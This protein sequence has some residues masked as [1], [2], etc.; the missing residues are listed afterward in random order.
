MA[1][2][3]TRPTLRRK[4]LNSVLSCL[5][6]DRIGPGELSAELAAG[7]SRRL[8]AGG[9]I[10]LSSYAAAIARAVELLGLAPGDSVVMSALTPGIYRE[11]CARFGIR[12]A[13]VDIEERSP[14]LDVAAVQR[15]LSGAERPRALVLHYTFGFLP[16]TD[17]VLR[18]G[19]PVVEDLSHALG[20]S[21]NGGPCGSHGQLAILSLQPDGIVTTGQGA[22]LVG[23][24]RRTGRALGAWSGSYALDQTL[25]NMNAALGLA[26][27]RELD[28][29]L[30]A[31]QDIAEGYLQ[32]VARSPHGALTA[33]AQSAGVAPDSEGTTG[34]R[35]GAPPQ[36]GTAAQRRAVCYGFAVTVRGGLK[37]VRQYA[38]KRGVETRRA[39]ADAAVAV[40]AAPTGDPA[41]AGKGSA[42]EGQGSASEA[43][44]PISQG[45]EVSSDSPGEAAR[46]PRAHECL[47]RSLQ[48]PLYPA[49]ARK[50]IQL[51]TR[52]LASLP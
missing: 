50:D 17:D 52:V 42:P 33:G 18:L 47:L 9:G 43:Q 48:F 37:E 12:V 8:G 32:A 35:D 15:M 10:C 30:Q 38:A 51:V 11:V 26:Q 3:V 16:E 40:Q 45:T 23:R 2:P 31:R 1:I 34:A 7:L 36:E 29:F 6:S 24:E 20:G 22:A 13:L 19:I 49:L 21:W 27:L 46:F 39:F 5:V 4:D 44:A 14:L 41:L 28:R 25:P